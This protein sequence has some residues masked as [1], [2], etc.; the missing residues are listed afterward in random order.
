MNT[1][2]KILLHLFSVWIFGWNFVECFMKKFIGLTL[3]LD[4]I[5]WNW[6]E[7]VMERSQV[8]NVLKF[9]LVH[10]RSVEPESLI[11]VGL[12]KVFYEVSYNQLGLDHQFSMLGLV[13]L[14]RQL[15]KLETSTACSTNLFVMN[16]KLPVG[17]LVVFYQVLYN[18]LSL[19]LQLFVP[20]LLGLNCQVSE[21]EISTLF[22]TYLFGL[23][24]EL[25]IVLE[26]VYQS[27]TYCPL[28]LNSRYSQIFV[29][30]Q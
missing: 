16:P 6:T 27:S 3:E 2:I 14:N 11:S 10:F 17:L 24:L 26:C 12:L 8:H 9:N 5:W 25:S 30:K 20:G 29:P 18:L 7:E 22:T 13:D 19:K 21:H 15:S 4:P 28:D 1:C 23:N